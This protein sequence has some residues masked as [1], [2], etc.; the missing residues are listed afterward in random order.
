MA[1]LSDISP[2]S[3]ETLNTPIRFIEKGDSEREQQ[4]AE[5]VRQFIDL[6]GPIEN[7]LGE[8]LVFVDH[9]TGAH[10]CECH[11]RASKFIGSATTD[12]PLD[13]DEQSEY[14]ANREIVD[15]HVAFERMRSD[16]SE[17][18]SFSNIVAEFNPQLNPKFPLGVIGGQ[19]R[20][21]AIREALTSGIDEFHEVKV[22]FGLDQEQ[23][24]DVQ[25]VSNTVIAVSGDLYDRMVET[26]K[27]PELR[28]W[29]HQTGLLADGCDFGDKAQRSG[30]IT[31]R[32]ARTFILNFYEGLIHSKQQFDT[33]DTSPIIPS[34]GIDD[35]KWNALRSKKPSIWEDLRLR[36]AG[37]E[38][39]EL[40]DAQRKAIE[41]K[42]GPADYRE[43]AMNIA[44]LAAWAYIAGFLTENETRLKRH[45]ALKEKASGDPLNSSALAKGRHKTDPENYRG[46]GTRTDAKE[47][48]RLV[49]LFY[50]QAENGEGITKKA[51]EVAIARYYAKQGQLEV[52]RLE[53]GSSK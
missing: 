30:P 51:I 23:R 33:T 42:K 43:K 49:E 9:R 32:L 38:F 3:S 15:D 8:I 13:P 39:A 5:L 10:Y 28:K 12:V 44:I 27:G 21:E 14:R 46:L 31:V 48:G 17:R 11:V 53:G 4:V 19:H 40:V 6:F 52:Q 45:F 1:I 35:A 22:Y 47:R 2:S 37:I 24:L 36:N 18:R 16:A 50:Y 20:T 26:V 41:S 25:V 34:V 29:C 7:E